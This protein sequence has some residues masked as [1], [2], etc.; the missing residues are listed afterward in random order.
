M[1]N[2]LICTT[3][4]ALLLALPIAG[5]ESTAKPPAY[6][7]MLESTVAQDDAGDW[8]DAVALTAKA[9]AKHPKGNFWAAYSELTGG[10]DETVHFFFP[11]NRLGDLDEWQ[12]NRKIINQSIGRDL[13]RIAISDLE[14][15]S[16]SSERILS[17]S[18]KL[19]RPWPDL[20][21]PKYAW[22]AQVHVADGKMTEYAALAKRVAKAFEES[23]SE[24]YWVVYGNAIGGD[25]SELVYFYGFDR[26]AEIDD[27]DARLEALAKSMADGE[28][29]R[30]VAA[31][32][33]VS[34]TTTSLWQLEPD[35]SQFEG[36]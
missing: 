14:L 3:L 8:A 28:A 29:E 18:A 9:H 15:A 19:S 10:P 16:D 31:M 32:E 24:G 17:Y 36:E 27:W 1:K 34:E 6:F 2:A 33:A 26:F 22:V 20:Q 23:D 30:L 35:L 12:S 11:L 21:A 4:A 25:S 7:F 13:G 5:Q